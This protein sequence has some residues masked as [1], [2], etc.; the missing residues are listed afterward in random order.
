M[1]IS[2][3][4]TEPNVLSWLTPTGTLR[5][6]PADQRRLNDELYLAPPMRKSRQYPKRRHYAGENWFSNTGQHVWHESLFERH[7]LLWLDFHHDIVAIASQ[8]MRMDFDSGLHHFPDLLALHADGH[9]VVYDIKPA[10]LISAKARRQFDATAEICK[11]VGWGYEIISGFDRVTSVNLSWLSNFRQNHYAPPRA[12]RE[13]L[14]AALSEPLPLA[15][16]ATAFRTGTRNAHKGW[17]YHLAWVG[18]LIFDLTRP[19]TN[20]TLIR[21]AH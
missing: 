3:F 5:V 15:E 10:E 2:P 20:T 7:S 14:L 12:A 13:L 16:A 19:I 17:L 8:P 9:Q 1:T 6:G 18:D 21:K 4:D 11:A